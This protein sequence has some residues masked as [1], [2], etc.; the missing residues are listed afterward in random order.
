M[1]VLLFRLFPAMAVVW[2]MAVSAQTEDLTARRPGRD[3]ERRL[4][5]GRRNPDPR[6]PQCLPDADRHLAVDRVPLAL[7]EGM[8]AHPR[9]HEEIAPGDTVAVDRHFALSHLQSVRARLAGTI[10][11]EDADRLE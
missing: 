4:A 7:K 6:P 8:L 1:N 3:D 5:V 2:C 10:A 9:R 11:R